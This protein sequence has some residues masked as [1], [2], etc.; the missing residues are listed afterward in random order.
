VAREITVAILSDTKDFERGMRRAAQ[1]TQTFGQKVS[2][3][4]KVAGLAIGAGLAVAA[5][6]G[7]DELAEG[8]KVSA[9]TQA[10]L[11]STGGAANVTAGHIEDLAGKLQALSGADDEAIQAG[12]N[13]LLTF[14]NVQNR[15]G[16]GNDIFDQATT[17]MLDMSTALGQDS[18]KSAM[19]L[20]KALNDPVRGLSALRRVGVSFTAAQEKSIKAMVKHGNVA[21]AQKLILA[22]LSKEF[23]GSA[24]AAGETLPGKLNKA[25]GAF[26]NMAGSL[27]ESLLPAITIVAEKLS[28]FAGFLS[29]HEGLTKGLVVGLG[30]LAAAL[31]AASVA[32]TLLNL[33]MFANPIGAIVLAIV[34]LGVAIVVAWKRFEIFRNVVTGAIDFVREHWRLLLA[35][36]L[37]PLGV[38]IG[39]AIKHFGTLKGIA[40]GVFTAIKGA[41]QGAIDKVRT[42]RDWLKD[43]LGNPAVKAAI[44]NTLLGPFKRVRD[45]VQRI[46]D[47]IQVLIEWIKKI[48]SPSGVVGGLLDKVTPGATGISNFKGGLALVGERGPELLN[49]PR[50]SDVV[51]LRPGGAGAKSAGG[52]TVINFHFPN[53]IASSRL[54]LIREIDR[55]LTVARRGGWRG[56]S[57]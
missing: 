37:G 28:A 4:A 31:I 41:I 24:K 44:E 45:A 12:E 9:Q 3:G 43:K 52:P 50:G 51:P 18:T 55:A 14:T 40:V 19:L 27:M 39:F 34:A 5:K 2:R 56:N 22:E 13:L 36:L 32:Q 1:A 10:A 38:A 53:H 6:V 49:L 29:K 26:E 54:E 42:I 7:W 46:I 35:I 11:K 15:V 47:A 8:Q 30:V 20:G 57:I 48:P 23:G 17:T 25:K 33:A 21:G 16:K